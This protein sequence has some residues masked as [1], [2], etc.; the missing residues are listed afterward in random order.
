M[1]YL[2]SNQRE[3][4]PTETNK[5]AL[6]IAE[7][8]Q[9]HKALNLRFLDVSYHCSYADI[10]VLMSAT[11]PRHSKALADSIAEDLGLRKKDVEGYQHG[12][13]VVLD[14]GDI[15]VHIF[16]EPV[17]MYY[18]LDKLWS[19]VPTV[20][21]QSLGKDKIRKASGTQPTV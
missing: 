18:N 9:D 11:S 6:L 20:D 13:W 19:H 2:K 7:T 5:K 12:E 21:F 8:A 1:V 17:R 16:F 10:F 14:L 3:V 4:A 15:V